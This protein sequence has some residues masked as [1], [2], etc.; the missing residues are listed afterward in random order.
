MTRFSGSMINDSIFALERTQGSMRT[1]GRNDGATWYGYSL[2]K[3]GGGGALMCNG[4][5][6]KKSLA[7]GSLAIQWGGLY[8]AG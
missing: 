4:C 1:E 5:R 6:K 3:E 8:S 2:L 7:T